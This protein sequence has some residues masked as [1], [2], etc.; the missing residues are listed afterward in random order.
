M[1]PSFSFNSILR[2]SF[3]TEVALSDGSGWVRQVPP[4]LNSPLVSVPLRNWQTSRFPSLTFVDLDLEREAATTDPIL[5]MPMIVATTLS[6]LTI[7][8]FPRANYV[9]S[10][11]PLACR[12][13]LWEIPAAASAVSARSPKILPP[14]P[15][16]QDYCSS[17]PSRHVAFHPRMPCLTVARPRMLL[18]TVLHNQVEGSDGRHCSSPRASSLTRRQGLTSS[19]ISFSQG[20]RLHI[21]VKLEGCREMVFHYSRKG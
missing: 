2:R 19:R 17:F 21:P 16:L 12:A 6:M 5:K 18:Q 3:L 10:V 4:L 14:H 8:P 9:F 13:V 11:I 7:C 15:P 20:Q 1:L